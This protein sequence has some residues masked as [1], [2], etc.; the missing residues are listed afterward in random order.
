M[1]PI[2][3]VQQRFKRTAKAAFT[4]VVDPIVVEVVY[5]QFFHAWYGAKI[6]AK[7]NCNV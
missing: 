3:S 2:K 6:I 4:V 5:G 7:K 1:R